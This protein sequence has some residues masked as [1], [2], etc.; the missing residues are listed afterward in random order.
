MYIYLDGTELLSYI[1]NRIEMKPIN[2][3]HEFKIIE[4]S[5]ICV[6]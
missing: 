1:E 4:A 2:V 5:T 3:T 6:Y